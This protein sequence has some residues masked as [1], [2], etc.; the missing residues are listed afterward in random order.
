MPRRQPMALGDPVCGLR[1]WLLGLMNV[2]YEA[3][4]AYYQ[5]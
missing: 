4:A 2:G 5:A 3:V 1:C